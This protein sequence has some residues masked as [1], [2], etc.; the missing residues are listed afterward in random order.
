MSL[1]GHPGNHEKLV[2]FW[3]GFQPRRTFRHS[4]SRENDG[5]FFARSRSYLSAHGAS[6]PSPLRGSYGVAAAAT[7]YTWPVAINAWRSAARACVWPNPAFRGSGGARGN[8][9]PAVFH[10]FSLERN[11]SNRRRKYEFAGCMVSM[12]RDFTFDIRYCLCLM[13]RLRGVP[14]IKREVFLNH[15]RD[16]QVI[17]AA[18]HALFAFGAIT[19]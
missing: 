9:S 10:Y 16:R 7:R 18:F 15:L 12:I 13:S 19:Y 3:R 5:H 14:L 4:L 8:H 6:P 17:G 2:I 1:S 11:S